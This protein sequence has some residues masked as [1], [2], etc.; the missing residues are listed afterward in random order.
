M[1]RRTF[2]TGAL[3]AAAAAHSAAAQTPALVLDF[4]SWQA[5]EP[6]VSGWWKA[7]IAEFEAAN[8][9]A[10]VNLYSIPFTQYV[11]QLTVRFA[12]NNA[13]DIVHL[14]TRN[15]AAFASQGWLAPL[16]DRL[17][18]T[19]I[20][21]SWTPLQSEMK[22]EGKTQG[23]LLMGY[24][25][26]LYYNEKLLADAGL[27]VPTTPAQWL[28]AIEKTTKRDQGQFGLVATSIEHPNLVV[29]AGTWVMGQGLDWLRQ[30]RYDFANAQVVAAV[31][32]YRRSMRFAPPGMNSTTGRQ[33]FIDGKAT[34]L[35]DGP[36]V[37]A[38]V[39]RAPEAVRPHLK[40]AR[41]PFPKETGGTSNSLHMPANLA[42]NK[43]ELVWKFF[44]L[45]ASPKWQA[46]Y[47]LQSASPAP[48]RG[49]LG[50][51]AAARLPHLK[52]VMDAA[53]SAVSVFPT[54]PALME[55]YNEYASIFGRA[56][57]RLIS[58]EEPTPTV[59]AGLQRE[60]ERAV[61]LR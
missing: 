6:G 42:A 41:V 31:D 54:N 15:F 44:E 20:L 4:P 49:S 19:D 52:L 45:A 30:G 33:L 5:E 48:R 13:P 43:R 38:F 36:W 27:S 53:A 34:F 10:K 58:T 16:D 55:G 18:R 9:G 2:L 39:A 40:V 32:Q 51:D 3:A 50:A 22:W 1:E 46:E 25:S 56:M 37:W 24:G 29:E 59:M 35:R 23:L 14:P 7:V 12:G 60:L 17:A 11:Q 21:Q 61:P 8:P 28:E 26:L 47:V 57:M